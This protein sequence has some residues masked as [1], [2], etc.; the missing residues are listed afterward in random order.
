MSGWD[1]VF[2]G[3]IAVATLLIAALQIGAVVV[4]VRLSR[5]VERLA[6]ELH[7]EVKPL[8]ARASLIAEDAQRA[9]SLAV[10]QM[11][12]ADVLM[13]DLS[14]RIDDTA[15]VLQHAVITPVRE[16]AA[17]IAGVKAALGLLRGGRRAASGAG[18]LD[19]EDALF[20]G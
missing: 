16:G 19:E 11:E 9:A 20:I 7:A 17:I 18:R 12:R 2:L 1:S 8:A 13:S 10:A 5:R 4:A 3:A 6:D 14:R 15:A